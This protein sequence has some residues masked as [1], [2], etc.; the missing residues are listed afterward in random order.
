MFDMLGK[1]LFRK[2]S[3]E[4]LL[5]L[6][7][8]EL[9]F[10]ELHGP[11][12]NHSHGNVVRQRQ[13]ERKLSTTAGNIQHTALL[14]SREPKG[15]DEPLGKNSRP[16]A[17]RHLVQSSVRIVGVLRSLSSSPLHC[18]NILIFSGF[19]MYECA[20]GVF[21]HS[22]GHKK[23]AQHIVLHAVISGSG[24]PPDGR[25]SAPAKRDDLASNTSGAELMTLPRPRLHNIELVHDNHG[26]STLLDC[27][28]RSNNRPGMRSPSDRPHPPLA[29][30]V[31]RTTH[32]TASTTRVS[33]TPREILFAPR[34]ACD[35]HVARCAACPA[36]IGIWVAETLIKLPHSPPVSRSDRQRPVFDNTSRTR[37]LCSSRTQPTLIQDE[38][39]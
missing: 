2:I 30:Q 26:S 17:M 18:R 31:G 19:V 12:V 35:L 7:P 27:S 3:A 33:L 11:R 22:L 9:W 25:R 24:C 38:P 13:L 6:Q 16:L 5:L 20:G 32:R 21:A 29:R 28:S 4:A 36:I 37:R 14:Q 34:V 8:L 15:R 10:V 23:L 1:P 39:H